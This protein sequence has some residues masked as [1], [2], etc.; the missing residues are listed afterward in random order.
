MILFKNKITASDTKKI[1]DDYSL[2]V[3]IKVRRETRD[4]L[5]VASKEKQNF[6]EILIN[7]VATKGEILRAQF[8][9]QMLLSENGFA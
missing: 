7:K 9:I 5:V 3:Y 8:E 4:L 1:I 6:R 2:V